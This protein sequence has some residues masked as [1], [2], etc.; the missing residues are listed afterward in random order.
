MAEFSYRP[1]R[2]DEMDVAADQHRLAGELIPGFDLSLHSAQDTR[3]FYCETVF[4][5]GPVWGAFDG[6]TL[7][8]HMALKPGWIDH[9]YVDPA[10]H[11]RGI[12]RA[13]IALAQDAAAD[14]QLYTYAANA[15]A[16]RLYETAGFVVEEHG[17][18]PEHGNRVP[19]VR[20]RWRRA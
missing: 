9:L 20:Y 5:G 10:H 14:L 6:D 2:R 1:L 18:D 16:R 7:V 19:N 8:G 4:T 17:F 3:A 11:G 12:G 15:R 13:L